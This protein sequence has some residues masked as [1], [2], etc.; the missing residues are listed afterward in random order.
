MRRGVISLVAWMVAVVM[1][2]ATSGCATTTDTVAINGVVF[3][4]S[5][6]TDTGSLLTLS[7]SPANTAPLPA[8]IT[9]NS[10]TTHANAQGKFLMHIRPAEAYTC[11]VSVTL[12]L[13][14][15]VTVPGSIGNA[16][17]L[18]FDL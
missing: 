2:V 5:V 4:Q 17:M 14:Q 16:F 7:P 18:A 10:I 12:Y 15:E 11:S 13:S 1:V 9:C 8:A 3:G 6:P